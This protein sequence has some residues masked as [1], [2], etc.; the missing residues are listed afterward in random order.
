MSEE[1]VVDEMLWVPSLHFSG[2]SSVF[3]LN[4]L[5][6]WADFDWLLQKF[7]SSSLLFFS[8]RKVSKRFRPFTGKFQK[9]NVTFKLLLRDIADLIVSS[10]R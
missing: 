8:G 3:K 1:E 9:Q 7:T 5:K 4:Q 10:Q 2:V 6:N